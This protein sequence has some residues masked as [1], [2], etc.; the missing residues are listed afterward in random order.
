M[1]IEGVIGL[2]FSIIDM[3]FSGLAALQFPT[4][5]LNLITVLIDFMKVG[6][7]VVGADLLGIVFST[8][9]FWLGFKF[10]AGLL[11]FIWRLLPLT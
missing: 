1:I 4:L 11:V 2:A 3:I 10:T 5:P 6:A 8:I 7:W 9:I